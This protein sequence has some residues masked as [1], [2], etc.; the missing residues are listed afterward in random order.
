M[1]DPQ[2][3]RFRGLA[4]RTDAGHVTIALDF[5]PAAVWGERARYVVAGTVEGIRFRTDLA[6]R[7]GAWA[8]ALGP[9]SPAA[10]RLQDGQAV[11]V[12]I[13]PEGPQV[14]ALAPDIVAALAARPAARAA[15]EALATFYRKGWLRWIDA[16][17]RR[18]D[19]RAQRIAEMLDLLEAGHKERR[20]S[21]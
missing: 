4:R 9:R 6:R 10:G 16:T 15:F 7:D 12:E 17:K 18:P 1:A 8:V 5:D 20:A 11:T 19:V 2:R 21:G 14:D 3:R 13:E